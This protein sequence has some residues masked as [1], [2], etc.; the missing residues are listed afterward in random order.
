MF[1]KVIMF[2]TFFECMIGIGISFVS[3][4]VAEMQKYWFWAQ[5]RNSWEAGVTELEICEK[6]LSRDTIP[7]I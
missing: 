1:Q 2:A 6:V 5:D 4:L 7:R 3:E